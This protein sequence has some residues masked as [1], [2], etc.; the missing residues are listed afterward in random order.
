[1][2]LD[3]AEYRRKIEIEKN[4][5]RMSESQEASASKSEMRE[6][7]ESKAYQDLLAGS[8]RN[9]QKIEFKRREVDRDRK[10]DIQIHK[11]KIETRLS[12]AR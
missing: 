4:Q 8:I 3:L 7:R 11:A 12:N 2:K 5:R 10:D 1:M 9:R 6:E